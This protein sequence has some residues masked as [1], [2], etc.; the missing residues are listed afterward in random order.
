MLKE[1]G[2]ITPV[3]SK[4]DEEYH[5]LH[6]RKKEAVDSDPNYLLATRD[7]VDHTCG[8]SGSEARCRGEL[9]KLSGNGSVGYGCWI[10][11]K[12]LGGQAGTAVKKISF[13]VRNFR[14]NFETHVLRPAVGN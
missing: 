9:S 7:V 3:R 10:M 4:S 11:P 14:G 6:V 2:S 5:L 12:S 8:A 1:I 13:L